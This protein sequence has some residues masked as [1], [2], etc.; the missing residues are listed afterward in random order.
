M[1]EGFDGLV[2]VFIEES[3]FPENGEITYI[4][5]EMDS[6]FVHGKVYNRKYLTKNKIQFNPKLT[7]HEDSYFNCLAQK[8]ST[9]I[10]YCQS[11]FYL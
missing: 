11:P 3:R 7:V 6:T 1:V 2:S 10:K 8:C 4:N 9:N 5:R